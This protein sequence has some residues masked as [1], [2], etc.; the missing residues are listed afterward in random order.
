[1]E[2]ILLRVHSE[3]L[4]D[5]VAEE[6]GDCLESGLYTDLMVRCKDGDTLHAH[7]LVLSAA[8]PFLRLVIA[9]NWSLKLF[10]CTLE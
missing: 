5:H 2:E 7:K 4:H 3:D 9:T 1:M 8:S 10:S 6:V